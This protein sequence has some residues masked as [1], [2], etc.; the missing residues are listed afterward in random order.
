MDALLAA[1]EA[2]AVARF[3]KVSWWAYPLVNVV[4]VLGLAALFGAILV[5]DLRRLGAWGRIDEA[6]LAGPAVRVAA[7][8]V[9]VAAVSGVLLFS[10]Q[11]AQYAAMT[12]FQVKLAA[13][14]VGLLNAGAAHLMEVGRRRPA[15]PAA[16]SVLAWTV[17]IVAGRL[18]GYWES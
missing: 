18:I 3:L 14:A 17:A 9:A 6:A 13:V 5:L 7:S 8:G 11:A 12:V 2:T 15:V 4:H 1:L 10:V 16:V